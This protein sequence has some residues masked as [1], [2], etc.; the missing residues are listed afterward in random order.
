MSHPN[1]FYLIA[2]L[3]DGHAISEDIAKDK[4]D[5]SFQGAHYT[6]LFYT[7]HHGS[8]SKDKPSSLLR[9]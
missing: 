9:A 5:I 8:E 6:P 3:E 7:T 4:S 2:S 1:Q